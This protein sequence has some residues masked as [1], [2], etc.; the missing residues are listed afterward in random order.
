MV[1]HEHQR[2]VGWQ[3]P[4]VLPEDLQ[5]GDVPGRAGG[6]ALE[7]VLDLV[8][9]VEAQQIADLL[10]RLRREL[11]R[12]AREHLQREIGLRAVD[13][14][15]QQTLDGGQVDLADVLG[16]VDPE[17]GDSVSQEFVQVPGKGAAHLVGFGP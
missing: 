7:S 16:G 17:A 6:V 12:T 4:G 2:L 10:E 5:V 14:A 1:L 9:E 11:A 15:I 13:R 8:G 3:Q